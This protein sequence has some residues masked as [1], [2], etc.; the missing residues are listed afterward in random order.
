[1]TRG[2][3][4]RTATGACWARRGWRRGRGI[5]YRTR[6][7]HTNRIPLLLWAGTWARPSRSLQATATGPRPPSIPRKHTTTPGETLCSNS[8]RDICFVSCKYSIFLIFSLSENR[9]LREVQ[10]IS[11]PSGWSCLYH[12]DLHLQQMTMHYPATLIIPD[13]EPTCLMTS[14]QLNPDNKTDLWEDK[15]YLCVHTSIHLCI[16]GCW[17]FSLPAST[18]FARWKKEMMWVVVGAA[19]FKKDVRLWNTSSRRVG[20]ATFLSVCFDFPRMP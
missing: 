12:T 3:Q 16:N 5:T 7:R 10:N 20:T 4:W 11:N 9:I 6:K 18:E 2:P 17:N 8:I 1:M 14:I 15:T 19:L 13:P